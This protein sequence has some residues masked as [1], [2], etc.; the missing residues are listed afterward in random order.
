M[1]EQYYQLAIAGSHNE[2]LLVII[3]HSVHILN[4]NSIY[5]TVKNKP[6]AIWSLEQYTHTS[7]Q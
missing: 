7:Y 1:E 6:L 5:W 4:P 3:Q 2:N